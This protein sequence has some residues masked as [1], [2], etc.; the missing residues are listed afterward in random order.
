[1]EGKEEY[2]QEQNEKEKE[3]KK[4]NEDKLTRKRRKK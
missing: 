4:R 3:W 1:M 2:V